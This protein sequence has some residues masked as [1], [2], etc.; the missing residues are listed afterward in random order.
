MRLTWKKEPK[1]T[2]LLSVGASPRGAILRANGAEVASVSANPTGWMCWDGWYWVC[3]ANESIG[4]SCRNTYKT[5]AADIEAAKREC[6]S[7][8]RTGLGLPRKR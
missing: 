7:Y 5:P 2:G 3:A 1:E 4:I 6:E 8:I